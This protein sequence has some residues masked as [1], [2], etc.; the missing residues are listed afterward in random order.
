MVSEN[1]FLSDL[2]TIENQKEFDELTKKVDSLMKI[3]EDLLRELKGSY[4]N[5][6][7]QLISIFKSLSAEL[8]VVKDRL[9]KVKVDEGLSEPSSG[10][11][12]KINVDLKVTPTTIEEGNCRSTPKIDFIDINGAG[13][14]NSV[15]DYKVRSKFLDYQ[16]GKPFF[17]EYNSL[18]VVSNSQVRNATNIE[19]KDF[20]GLNQNFSTKFQPFEDRRLITD[21]KLNHST[22]YIFQ[23]LKLL[24]RQTTSVCV[25][26]SSYDSVYM[27]FDRGK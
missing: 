18:N 13:A 24:S 19:V 12:P 22:S 17:S 6:S 11:I 15:K 14:T 27:L 5:P 3:Q 23:F 9:S 7:P 26:L 25:V 20:N 4:N 1:S 8:K 16:E 21:V 2:G 10:F